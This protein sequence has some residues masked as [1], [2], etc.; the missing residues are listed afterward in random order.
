[1]TNRCR[2]EVDNRLRQLAAGPR[3]QGRTKGE[4]GGE[5]RQNTFQ[6]KKR[7]D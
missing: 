2:L 3:K 5:K 6:T 1:M 7:T 4:V